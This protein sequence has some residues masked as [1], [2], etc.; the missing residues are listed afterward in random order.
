MTPVC[1]GCGPAVDWSRDGKRMLIED[2]ESKGIAL[3]KPG[4]PDKTRLLSRAGSTLA[5]PHFSPDERWIAFTSRT[6]PAGSRIYVAPLRG[7][8]PVAASEWVSLTQSDA[9]EAVPQWSPDGKLVYFISNRDG[10]RCIWARRFEE[11]QVSKGE[12]FPVYHFH[13]ARR[14]PANTPLQASDL[15]VG[16]DQMVIGIGQLAGSLW[17][18]SP[19][20]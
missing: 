7:E 10:Q 13:D 3:A 6:E 9:W 20:E 14:S 16:K 1:Q 15:F 18:T 8:A 19:A 4:S 11:A 12:P 17:M 2:L 5:E